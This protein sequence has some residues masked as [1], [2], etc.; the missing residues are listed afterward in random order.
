MSEM[1]KESIKYYLFFN[2]PIQIV[3]IVSLFF[4]TNI[5]VFVCTL[6]LSYILVYWLGVQAGTHKLFSHKTWEPKNNFIKNMIATLSC[7]GLMGGPI[8]WSQIH[9]YHHIHADTDLDPHTP[10]FGLLNSYF[11]W[12][13]NIPE[14]KLTSVKDLIKDQKLIFINKYCR[15]I[16]LIT[17]TILFL[18]NFNL[19]AGF[20][21]ACC[22]T[23]HSEMAVNAFLHKNVNHKWTSVNNKL[24]SLISGGS[25]L[26][27]NHHDNLR[28]NNFSI[29]PYEFDCSYLFIKFL[30]K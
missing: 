14:L 7:F 30:S 25:T 22:L 24:L 3:A 4:I 11:L 18:I 27:K 1:K 21:M 6:V 28:L 16:V 17:L 23:F 8:I 10:K 19:F 20:I 26:H 9:R 2:L 15:E 29:N 12:L 5:Y 13:F